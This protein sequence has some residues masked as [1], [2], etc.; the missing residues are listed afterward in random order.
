MSGDAYPGQSAER[1]V[2]EAWFDATGQGG[3]PAAELVV[4]R[5][6]MGLSQAQFAPLMGVSSRAIKR[7]E[8]GERN[9]TCANA[10]IVARLEMEFDAEV[11]RAIR[12]LGRATDD[13]RLVIAYRSDA[14]LHAVHPSAGRPASWGRAVAGAV[15][16]GA[17][18]VVA[19]EFAPAAP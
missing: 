13:E 16:F 2:I 3:I 15:R 19:V 5:E 18:F 9:M 4:I 1:R 7:W 17:P 10:D 11:A 14:D 12:A 8:G 6:R